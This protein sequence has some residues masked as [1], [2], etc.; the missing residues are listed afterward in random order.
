VVHLPGFN[1]LSG[2]ATEARIGRKR[3][4]RGGGRRKREARREEGKRKK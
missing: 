4:R 2:R 3:E 1:F